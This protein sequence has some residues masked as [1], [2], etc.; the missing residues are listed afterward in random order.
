MKK[1]LLTHSYFYQFDA[2][3][4]AMGQPYAPYATLIVAALLKKN[5][6]EVVFFDTNLRENVAEIIPFF[7]KEKPDFL[8]IFD[9]SFNYLSKMC[10]TN[11]R[12]AC[13]EMLALGKKFGTQNIVCS[14]DATDHAQEYLQKNADFVLLGE[15]E[16]T[17]LELLGNLTT[18]SPSLK[19]GELSSPPS[20]GGAGGSF[21]AVF[22]KI[23]GL[24]F[25][26]DN[27]NNQEK[28][29]HKTP[30]REILK[31]LDSLPMPAWEL[32]DIQSY[33]KIWL[34]K[35]G[36]FGVNIATTRGCPYKCNWCAKPIYGTRYNVRSPRK[37][38]EEIE[39]LTLNFKVDYFWFADDIF[40]LKPA[41]VQ[42]FRDI[43]KEK[44]L[45]IKYK[46]QSRVD[47][48][49]KEDTIKALAE[50]GLDEVWVGAESGAQTI[51]D[52][53]DKG[54]KVEEIY[55]A[56]KLLKQNNIK[57]GFFLQYGYLGETR[58][59]INQTLKMVADLLPDEIGISVSYPLP[60]TKFYDIVKSQLIEK[61][62]WTDSH[63]LSM[64]YKGTFKT[65]FYKYLHKYTHTFFRKE[66]S[67]FLFYHLFQKTDF[68]YTLKHFIKAIKYPLY[69]LADK[70]GQMRLKKLEI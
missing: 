27:Q 61:Q 67:K 55:Q 40:G 9:D 38:V 18:P 44:S 3:Q 30:K 46:I 39:Y 17:L 47:L 70:I 62:N 10:L 54:T 64:M 52:A 48:L 35:R 13:F 37:I 1:V 45:K 31:D 69:I 4:W 25:L 12:E 68:S 22:S 53:M 56:T 29:L 36:Y 42:E 60:N 50:S 41:W 26:E 20:Q 24:A 5:G 63:D 59:N 34:D 66:K 2:K 32:V 65:D 14:S 57:V 21:D 11:M 7:E 51:L 19:I 15:G 28:N 6:Y 58:Q 49:L 43:L 33:R 23:N 16:L 8:V